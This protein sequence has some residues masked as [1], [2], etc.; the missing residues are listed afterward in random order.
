[1]RL[2]IDLRKSERDELAKDASPRDFVEVRAD[3]KDAELVMVPS[4]DALAALAA[5]HV[6]QVHGPESLTGAIDG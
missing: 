4:A 1:M 5:Q 3:A 6:D 2:V